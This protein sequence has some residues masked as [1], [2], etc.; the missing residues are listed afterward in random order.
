MDP[1]FL[2]LVFSEEG[3]PLTAA[4]IGGDPFYILDDSGFRRHVQAR[5][6]DESILRWLWGQIR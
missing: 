5:A 2:G 3:K 6:L 4:E 1:L